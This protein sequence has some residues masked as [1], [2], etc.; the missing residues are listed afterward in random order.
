MSEPI[1]VTQI[2]N[3]CQGYNKADKSGWPKDKDG[4]IIKTYACPTKDDPKKICNLELEDVCNFGY[5]GKPWCKYDSDKK[6]CDISC[7]GRIAAQPNDAKCTTETAKARQVMM[8][9]PNNKGKYLLDEN[10]CYKMKWECVDCTTIN[11]ENFCTNNGCF[12]YSVDTSTSKNKN[13][14]DANNKCHDTVSD[15]PISGTSDACKPTTAKEATDDAANIA[16]SM[17]MS[18]ECKLEAD[19]AAASFQES[20]A[21]S[22]LFAKVSESVSGTAQAAHMTSSGCGNQIAQLNDFESN[23]NNAQ[24]SMN[25]VTNKQTLDVTNKQNI[26]FKTV[27][28]PADTAIAQ[29]IITLC[30]NSPS[31]AL[32][33]NGICAH[34]TSLLEQI[35]NAG[36]INIDNSTIENKIDNTLTSSAQLSSE[37]ASQ[38]AASFNEQVKQAAA[39][40]IKQTLGTDALPTNTKQLIDQKTKDNQQTIN[41]AINNVISNSTVS[42]G[43]DQ[44]LIFESTGPITIKD[45]TIEQDFVLKMSADSLTRSATSIGMKIAS[46]II[47][48]VSSDASDDNKV[49]GQDDLAKAL[50]DANAKAIAATMAGSKMS[51]T[52]MIIMGVILLA[53]IGGGIFTAHKQGQ[54]GAA[55]GAQA[56]AKARKMQM[57]IYGI[58][59]LF[60]ITIILVSYFWI[61]G[62]F[63]KKK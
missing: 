42:Q 38:V 63:S 23:K 32:K 34:A 56:M 47:N 29:E 37:S 60:V 49:N 35:I 22:A 11:D 4:K 26:S 30:S 54:A 40:A 15:I 8:P 39:N 7:T 19:S 41:D 16:K 58:M 28:N 44:A 18:Q 59:V 25:S 21:G 61:K 17:G 13:P 45:S 43:A 53:V 5:G 24:C 57:I 52:Q 10:G 46:S 55:G 50:G 31:A 6:T 48:D 1:T 3:V 9:D 14:G 51:V 33:D 36:S 2:Q 12:W 20:A 27:P 62:F